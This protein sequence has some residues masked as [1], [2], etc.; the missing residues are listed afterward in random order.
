MDSQQGK[1]YIKNR[2]GDELK[3]RILEHSG[4]KIANKQTQ[5][6]SRTCGRCGYVNK[7]ESKYCEGKGCN[8]PQT[9]LTLDDITA[10][11]EQLALDDI[12]AAEEQLAFNEIKSSEQKK[13]S[14]SS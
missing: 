14:S 3:N 12:T 5:M 10:A 8:Y 13:V 1:R 6:V 9:Q 2:K 4:I 11:E 7:L